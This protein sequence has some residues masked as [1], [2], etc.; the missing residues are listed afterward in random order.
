MKPS[1]RQKEI[2][3]FFEFIIMLISQVELCHLIQYELRQTETPLM[4]RQIFFPSLP[5][6]VH[7]NNKNFTIEMEQK[8]FF[9][10]V[11]GSSHCV[12]AVSRVKTHHHHHLTVTMHC[13]R[14]IFIGPASLT[15]MFPHADSFFFL[16]K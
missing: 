11:I 3:G 4:T 6:Y 12:S 13:N 7:T 15:W 8:V 1:I 2:R 10:K 5:P 14:S 16:K 9:Y